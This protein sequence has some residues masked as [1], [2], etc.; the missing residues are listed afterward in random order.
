MLVSIRSS[1]DWADRW[2]QGVSLINRTGIV[3]TIAVVTFLFTM[4][5][6]DTA[7]GDDAGQSSAAFLTVASDAR[8]MALGGALTGAVSDVSATHW[9][10]AALAGLTEARVGLSHFLWYQD[11]SYDFAAASIPLKEGLTL[12][13]SLTYLGY[14]TIEGYDQN[15]NSTGDIRSTYDMAAG[16]SCGISLGDGVSAGITTK[17][18]SQSVA[19]Y[20]AATG[21]VDIGLRWEHEGLILGA[22]AA[23]VGG[24]LRFRTI[25]ESLPT[26]FSVGVAARPI[27][28][29]MLASI[30]WEYPRHGD[31]RLRGGAEISFGEHYFLRGGLS[32]N[33]ESSTSFLSRQASIGGGA[34]IGS[35]R[36]D[37]AFAP[38]RGGAYDD[39][40]CFTFGL[41]F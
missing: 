41:A 28:Q 23:D 6:M 7:F 21:A 2:N 26:R 34:V 30:D 35:A 38:A 14:G 33:L 9:N 39:R 32:Q 16:L 13:M 18:V 37:Y 5:V 12:G 29:S 10:P 25:D 20:K 4:A 31:A 8:G 3:V 1:V 27:G 40:H 19:G 17:Y 15:N 36:F 22:R 11:M 24:Q